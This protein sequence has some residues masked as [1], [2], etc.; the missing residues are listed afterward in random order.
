LAVF[1]TAVCTRWI[2]TNVVSG[3]WL[4]KISAH[5][6]AVVAANRQGSQHESALASERY[7]EMLLSERNDPEEA[8]HKFND[9][10]HRYSKLGAH[11]KVQMLREKHKYLWQK[12][13]DVFISR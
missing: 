4:V 3:L 8:L 1:P 12:P 6:N 9:V 13:T 5:Q 11:K 2:R 10:I 7:G